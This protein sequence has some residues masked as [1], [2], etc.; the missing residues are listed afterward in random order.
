MMET[1]KRLK[2]PLTGKTQENVT[3]LR[4]PTSFKKL[5]PTIAKMSELVCLT[6]FYLKSHR[7]YMNNYITVLFHII[8]KP[9][10]S[11][12]NRK[13]HLKEPQKFLIFVLWHLSSYDFQ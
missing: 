6:L 10:L 11:Y 3:V 5:L 2:Y 4:K 7:P 9:K 13:Y 12:G 1:V 8:T